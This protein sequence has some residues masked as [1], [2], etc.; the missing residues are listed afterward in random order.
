[1]EDLQLSGKMIKEE[2]LTSEHGFHQLIMAALD[3]LK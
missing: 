1:M 2:A 3:E